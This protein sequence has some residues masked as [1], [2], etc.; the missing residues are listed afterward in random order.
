MDRFLQIV[1]RDLPTYD[2][3]MEPDT[4]ILNVAMKE[5]HYEGVYTLR[6]LMEWFSW[7]RPLVIS[8]DHLRSIQTLH[9]VGEQ[10]EELIRS[11]PFFR[12]WI[13]H[14]EFADEHPD[15]IWLCNKADNYNRFPDF[16]RSHQQ[17][18]SEIMHRHQIE[19]A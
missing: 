1:K 5:L 11:Y 6:V 16:S 13:Y 12:H 14:P 15:D 9:F 19:S 3:P 2:M 4:P 10:K 8:T 7:W 18:Y 17:V